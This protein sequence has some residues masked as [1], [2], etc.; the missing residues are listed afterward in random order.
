MRSAGIICRVVLFLDGRGK[1]LPRKL[2]SNFGLRYE[3][4]CEDGGFQCSETSGSEQPYGGCAQS[5]SQ[6]GSSS[7]PTATGLTGRR[8]GQVAHHQFQTGCPRHG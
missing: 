3:L 6:S 5:Q 4:V 8:W 2:A 7:G 1:V